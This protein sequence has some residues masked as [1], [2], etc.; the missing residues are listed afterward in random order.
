M[1]LML[2]VIITT[3]GCSCTTAHRICQPVTDSARLALRCQ[4]SGSMHHLTSTSPGQAD[5]F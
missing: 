2:Q 3:P 4:G 5:T 1:S